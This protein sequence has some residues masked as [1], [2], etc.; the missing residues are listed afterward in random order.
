MLDGVVRTVRLAPTFDHIELQEALPAM[1]RAAGVTDA[2]TLGHLA[3]AEALAQLARGRTVDA[4]ASLD[5][6]AD[7]FGSTEAA[8]QA[9]Q[10]RVLGPMFGMPIPTAEVQSGQ[11]RLLQIG[12][13]RAIWTMG[14]HAGYLGDTDS[15]ELYLAEL[16]ALA[17]SDSVAHHLTPMVQAQL[18][19]VRGDVDQALQITDSLL[20][21]DSSY[22]RGAVFARAVLHWQ[23]G[24]WL[25]SKGQHAAADSALLWYQHSHFV[26]YP[27]YEAA[28]A[29]A[30]AEVDWAV[31][32][33]AEFLLARSAFQDEDA[34]RACSR[35][36][37][38]VRIW[39]PADPG[40]HTRLTEA[41]DIVTKACR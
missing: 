11:D 17:A 24:D 33:G 13:A 37:R 18:Y 1:V 3:Q 15:V 39:A 27:I 34:D 9:A 30:A 4:L 12:G 28:A 35:A 40:F 25:R 7:L 38:V 5:V 41:R 10:W 20:V 16:G 21:A 36:R 14:L 23:R 2:Q 32:T 8:L 22:H 31:G 19:A 26:K 6:A 29:A